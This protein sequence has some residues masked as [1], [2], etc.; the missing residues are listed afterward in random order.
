MRLSFDYQYDDYQDTEHW[1]PRLKELE[2]IAGSARTL[3]ASNMK[4]DELLD[5]ME[6]LD[7]LMTYYIYVK[8]YSKLEPVMRKQYELVQLGRGMHIWHIGFQ[9]LDMNLTRADAF[10]Y[11]SNGDTAKA[12]EEYREAYR[13]AV[14]CK[15]DAE[16]S[17]DLT[18][19]QKIFVIWYCIVCICQAVEIESKL[20]DTEEILQ[21]IMTAIKFLKYVEENAEDY[22][23]LLE[24]G[25]QYLYNFAGQLY[26]FWGS[27]ELGRACYSRAVKWFKMLEKGENSDIWYAVS[28]FTQ[29]LN[30]IM[31]QVH[32]ND[33]TLAG[34]CA[35]LIKNEKSTG[36]SAAIITSA[37]GLLKA[38]LAI[39]QQQKGDLSSAIATCRE[40]SVLLEQALSQ[41]EKFTQNP[42]LKNTIVSDI[43]SRVYNSIV[44][45]Y[46]LQGI[47]YYGSDK[48]TE[49]KECLLHTQKLCARKSEFNTQNGAAAIRAENMMY[50]A[51]IATDE[52]DIDAVEFYAPQAITIAS[53][54]A[55]LTPA[56]SYVIA[57]CAGIMA[58]LCLSK[59]DKTSAAEYAEKGLAACGSLEGI[60][61]NIQEMQRN[62]EKLKKK[63]SR[64]WF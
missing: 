21:Y 62:L 53:E 7:E 9:Y 15:S 23:G 16:I 56:N 64:K 29:C 33:D 26:T 18:D 42:E 40:C 60:L 49:A 59:K 37:N 5:L 34:Q 47:C 35:A 25:G 11:Y 6:G 31:E 20:G 12:A 36:I 8:D 52:D 48:P 55:S 17:D 50:L 22:P 32:N 51:M 14:Q 39:S 46:E 4:E 3:N 28:V 58:E 43:G 1:L 24:K 54:A 38:Q 13:K 10:L 63:A 44:A 27:P 41:L 57:C 45:S 19:D 2:N 61:P 30:A